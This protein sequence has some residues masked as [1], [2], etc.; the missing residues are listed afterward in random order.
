VALSEVGLTD[1]VH[2]I[3]PNAVTRVAEALNRE[4]PAARVARIFELAGLEP[5]LTNPPQRMVDEREVSRL[6][7]VLR[8]ELGVPDALRIARAAGALTGDYLLA[9]RIPAAVKMLLTLLP[10]ALASRVLLDAIRRHSWTFAGSGEVRLDTTYPPR[11]A[12]A[13]CCIC[14][15]ERSEAPLCDFYSAAIQR[16]FQVLVRSGASVKETACQASGADACTF[17]ITWEQRGRA[18]GVS[19]SGA[20][21]R[22]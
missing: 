11:L 10:A 17:E 7:R 12:I 18:R 19:T 8:A 20:T 1:Q 13:G 15:G 14:R 6:H 3:G 22:R 5:Y 16:L 2:R 4:L 21:P 9:H